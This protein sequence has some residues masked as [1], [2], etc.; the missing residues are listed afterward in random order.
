MPGV[1][2]GNEHHGHGHQDEAFP[3]EGPRPRGRALPLPFCQAAQNT[4]ADGHRNVYRPA[5]GAA[6]VAEARRPK[7]VEMAV[8]ARM[9]SR[10]PVKI[11]PPNSQSSGITVPKLALRPM[12]SG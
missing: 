10:R 8:P 1:A 9:A 11:D 6:S 7:S 4:H 5:N 2:H 3:Q 12:M